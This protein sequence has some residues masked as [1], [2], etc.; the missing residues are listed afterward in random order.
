[1]SLTEDTDSIYRQLSACFEKNRATLLHPAY[2]ID[3]LRQRTARYLRHMPF[4]YTNNYV[5]N[6]GVNPRGVW[7][8]NCIRIGERHREDLGKLFGEVVRLADLHRLPVAGEC[9][10]FPWSRAGTMI[11]ECIRAGNEEEWRNR[12]FVNVLGSGNF[13]L[14]LNPG[15]DDLLDHFS[16]EESFLDFHVLSSPEGMIATR[17]VF[18]LSCHATSDTVASSE[19]QDWLFVN[20]G[21][22]KVTFV[23][24]ESESLLQ[25]LQRL[26]RTRWGYYC[27]D[28]APYSEWQFSEWFFEEHFRSLGVSASSLTVLLDGRLYEVPA[29]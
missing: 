9:I 26:I 29:E 27:T 7:P 17:N 10:D 2:P 6:I 23:S 22:S 24:T 18:R 13:F 15:A 19:L 5:M 16:K 21:S 8:R 14:V 1:M 25:R 4:Y 11:G 28:L 12:R 3:V 20:L